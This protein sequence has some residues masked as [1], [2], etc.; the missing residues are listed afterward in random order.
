MFFIF[1]LLYMLCYLVY[2]K[3]VMHLGIVICMGHVYHIGLLY[4]QLDNISAHSAHARSLAR[5]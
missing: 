4:G 3:C 2:V 5:I 1:L